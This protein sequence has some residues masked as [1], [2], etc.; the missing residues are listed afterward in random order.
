MLRVGSAG[1]GHGHRLPFGLALAAPGEDEVGDLLGV[2][3]GS[4]D[5]TGVLLERCDPPLD[6]GGPTARVVADAHAFARHHGA[7]LGTELFLRVGRRAESFSDSLGERVAVHPLRMAGAVSQ[8]V[9]R[10]LVVVVRGGELHPL[11]E[12]DL[13][14]VQVVERPVSGHVTDG[15]AAVFQHPLGLLVRL[16]ERL[17]SGRGPGREPVGLLG[18]EDG[19]L[20]DDGS[21][22]PLVAV[23]ALAFVVLDGPP[24]LVG[25]GDLPMVLEREDP[26]PLLALSDLAAP[27]LDLAVGSPADVDVAARL[28]DGGEVQA[29]A[30]RVGASGIDVGGQHALARPPGLLPRCGALADLLDDP[31]G[32]LAV[33]FVVFHR[34][35]SS[36]C[37]SSEAS[38]I[39]S[40]F[41]TSSG[42]RPYCSANAGRDL[43]GLAPVAAQLPVE[44]VER[45]DADAL[46]VAWHVFTPCRLVLHRASSRRVR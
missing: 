27:G 21:G 43:E 6:V 28:L 1:G 11:G 25:E 13:V 37:G 7:D 8:L 30:A 23:D 32:E 20:P 38:R 35:S 10:R 17:G 5:L 12:H 45:L 2:G 31:V 18:V 15:D 19:V 22:H 9:E 14:V 39:S 42:K 3:R 34:S 33:I 4:A 46:L 24:A 26:C 40:S 16:P 29:V 41:P 44:L 36:P